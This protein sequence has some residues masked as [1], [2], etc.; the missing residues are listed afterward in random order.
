M[1]FSYLRMPAISLAAVLVLVVGSAG[2]AFACVERDRDDNFHVETSVGFA[3]LAPTISLTLGVDKSTA[4]PGDKLTYS[5]RV[6][7]SGTILTVTGRVEISNPS[8]KPAT[9]AS[10]FDFLSVDPKGRCGDDDEDEAG[11][12]RD[13]WTPIRLAWPHR[14]SHPFRRPSRACSRPA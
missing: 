10:W 8:R 3:S 11:H 1:R 6:T 4:I 2:Q 14:V 9:V 7:N 5:A 13:H 12:D